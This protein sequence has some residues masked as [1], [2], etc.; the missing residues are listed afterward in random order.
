MMNVYGPKIVDR[1]KE[2]EEDVQV[3]VMLAMK[4]LL[5]TSLETTVETISGELRSQTSLIKKRSFSTGLG[6]LS[7]EIV[8]ANMAVLKKGPN[9]KV[10][11][12]VFA[13][14]QALVKSA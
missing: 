9:T 5:E 13:N 4:S 1:F 7:G 6:D 2:R 8:K 14:L 11:G 12:A 10:K 3:N